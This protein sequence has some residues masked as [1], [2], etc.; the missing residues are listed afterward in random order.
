MLSP[1][2]KFLIFK[3]IKAF[4]RNAYISL[5]DE[6]DFLL[7]RIMLKKF[8]ECLIANLR[9]FVPDS[10]MFKTILAGTDVHY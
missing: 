3:D 9:I 4:A 8:R 5:P 1:K 7:N 10:G 6:T 2:I